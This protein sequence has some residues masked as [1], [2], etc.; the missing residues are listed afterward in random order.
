MAT[1]K[2]LRVVLCWHMHQP[3][4]RDHLKDEFQLPWTYLHAIKDYTD[5]AAHLEAVPGAKAVVNF[6]PVL[7]DQLQHYQLQFDAHRRDGSPLRDP[8]LAALDSAVF[9]TD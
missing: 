5:M 6:S 1:D 2:A 7:L 9:P 4:Y 3:D 8:L